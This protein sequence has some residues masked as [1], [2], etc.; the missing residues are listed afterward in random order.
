M[1]IDLQLAT[2]SR[3]IAVESGE[4]L[5]HS[6]LAQGVGL[7][8]ECASG[9]CG[10]CRASLLSGS[11]D[12]LWPEAPG[13]K[14]LGARN[15]LLCQCAP[16]TD[17]TIKVEGFPLPIAQVP[18]HGSGTVQ[19]V[20]RLTS[21]IV[22][23][24]L[25]LDTELH[26]RAGQFVGIEAPD[27]P[28]F[29]SYSMVNYEEGAR[30]LDF[31][32]KYVPGGG[33]SEWLSSPGTDGTQARWFGPLGS[34]TFDPDRDEHLVCI[35]GGTGIAG[36]LAILAHANLIRYFSRN[37]GDVFFGVRTLRDSF[38]IG[39]LNKLAVEHPGSL[40]V[41]VAFSDAS[42]E[43]PSPERFPA[44]RFER[45][46]VHEVAA[47]RIIGKCSNIGAYVAGPTVAVNAAIKM[48]IVQAKVSPHSIR[49]DR[50]A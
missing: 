48:L 49:Y 41:V 17:C 25:E 10:A 19:N 38:F 30:R 42:S 37:P 40:N 47:R 45:G 46:L 9:T 2:G 1:L 27:V 5:L 15:F 14:N 39:E 18:R 13:A 44:L 22:K 33:F 23:F 43:I 3:K 7:P 6:S 4:R 8:Y 36:M 34:A 12:N 26:Y 20:E 11:I 31:V 29:R 50:F 24:S 32:M 35:A 21:D 28:G 16:R